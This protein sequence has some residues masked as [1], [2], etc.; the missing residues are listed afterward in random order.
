MFWEGVFENGLEFEL[1]LQYGTVILNLPALLNKN[2]IIIGHVADFPDCAD[3]ISKFEN[4][5]K[6]NSNELVNR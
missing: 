6:F 2:K 5:I 1:K 3:V 4:W